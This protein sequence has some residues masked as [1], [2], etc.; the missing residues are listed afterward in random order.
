MVDERRIGAVWM[1]WLV[2]DA[3]HRI[4]TGGVGPLAAVARARG[5]QWIVAVD[6]AA[7]TAGIGVG[8]TLA[9]ARALVPE[10]LTF[11]ADPGEDARRL[12]ALALWAGRFTPWAAPDGDDGIVLDL[13]GCAHLFGGEAALL[14]RLIHDLAAGGY[15][16]RAGLADTPATAFAVARYATT[17]HVPVRIVPSG[18][19][20]KAL[21]ELPVAALRLS[22][23]TTAALNS[24][25]LR[26][27]GDL[28][29]VPRVTLG[30]RFGREVGWRLDQALGLAPEPISPASPPPLYRARLALAEP[31][32]TAPALATAV[33]RLLDA[34]CRKLERGGMGARRLCLAAYRL[35]QRVDDAPQTVAIGTSRP[36]RDPVALARLF[37]EKLNRIAPGPGIE[38]M[39]LSAAPVDP[40]AASQ[41][42][43]E[44]GKAD[45]DLAALI[46]RLDN[47]LGAGAVSRL[48]PRQSWLPERAVA[49]AAPGK[50]VSSIG[51]SWPADRPRPVRLL[52]PPEPVEATA[53]V[54]DDPPLMFRWRGR[55]HR[56]RHAAGPERIEPEWWRRDG[57]PRDYYRVEDSDGHRFWL[58]RRGLY[59]PGRSPVWF[60]H[61]MFG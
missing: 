28:Y 48:I 11:D 59:Q 27:I 25:G 58:Y 40:L 30:P 2:T 26:R 13:A 20:R 55:V 42:N 46:D 53:P 60:L 31:I 7:E 36:E 45:A 9:D 24:L 50:T 15:E 18:G 41:E 16:A 44:R 38:V 34:V 37:A 54:P 32:S 56:I 23:T 6:R 61:G 39:T 12:Q 1:P 52:V 5:R 14:G 51:V 10:L 33:G 43:F 35:D 47:R 17:E 22:E 49:A 57:E 21:A 29:A 3:Y 19:Q 8:M 4:H